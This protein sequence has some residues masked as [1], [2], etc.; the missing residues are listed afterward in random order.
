MMKAIKVTL[1]EIAEEG[2]LEDE[3]LKHL[4]AARTCAVEA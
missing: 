2:A 1:K 3:E 4:K